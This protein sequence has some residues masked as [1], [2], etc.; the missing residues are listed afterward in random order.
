VAE[1]QSQVVGPIL[2]S[3]VSLDGHPELRLM[4]LAPMAVL[5]MQQRRGVGSALVDAGLAQ[6]RQLGVDAAVVLGHR[7]YYPRF[8]FAPALPYGIHCAFNA[9]PEA[10][11]LIELRPGALRGATG[12]VRFDPAFDAL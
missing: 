10:F 1:L 2:F 7:S 8:G 12:T 9:P 6:C 4:G 11:M 5:P 3:P